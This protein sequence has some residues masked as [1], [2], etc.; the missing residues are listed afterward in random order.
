MTIQIKDLTVLNELDVSEMSAVRGG[1][2]NWVLSAS[3]KL[4]GD[5]T[6][7]DYGLLA[8]TG[9]LDNP[10]DAIAAASVVQWGVPGY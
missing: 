9:A 2:D 10:A 4:W 8:E 1:L 3:G 6:V 7:K 5:L